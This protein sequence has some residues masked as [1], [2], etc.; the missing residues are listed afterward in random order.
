MAARTQRGEQ[1]RRQ[2][3]ELLEG[4]PADGGDLAD[5]NGRMTRDRGMTP[6]VDETDEEENDLDEEDDDEED[7][8]DDD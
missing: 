6:A 1:E 7:E 3:T 2:E 4:I 8:E 5:E